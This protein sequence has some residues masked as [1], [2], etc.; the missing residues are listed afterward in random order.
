VAIRPEIIKLAEMFKSQVIDVAADTLTIEA[1][2]DHN[3]IAQFEQLLSPYG[4]VEAARS[5]K[6]A[7][8]RG[9]CQ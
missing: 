9:K 4:I 7:L 8:P 2:G 5:G 3:T 1:T 6:L